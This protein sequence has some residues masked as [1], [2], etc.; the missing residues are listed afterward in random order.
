[1]VAN[2]FREQQ[3]L[4]GP[5]LFPIYLFV[6][7][8]VAAFYLVPWILVWTGIAVSRAAHTSQGLIPAVGS[9]WVAFWPMA[10]FMVG[11]I[12]VVFA[13][14]Q[15]TTTHA[16]DENCLIGDELFADMGLP[17]LEIF[18]RF[19]NFVSA[20]LLDPGVH[21]GLIVRSLS[22]RPEAKLH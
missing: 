11:S 21:A 4:I 18:I 17:S 2:G 5:V 15:I 16:R 1:M 14:A 19:I 20:A 10:F 6:L 12:T 3:H 8:I 13:A 9:F 7:K 22:G